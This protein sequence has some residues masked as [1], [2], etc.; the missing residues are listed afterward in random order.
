LTSLLQNLFGCAD[1]K[2]TIV[3]ERCDPLSTT[4]MENVPSRS[5]LK[6]P[7]FAAQ[8]RVFRSER[9]LGGRAHAPSGNATFGVPSAR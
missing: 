6:R 3:F 5:T 8:R 2:L 7:G 9:G 1:Y 4:A